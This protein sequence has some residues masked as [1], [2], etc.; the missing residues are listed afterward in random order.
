MTELN[1]VV[2]V[3]GGETLCEV[4]FPVAYSYGGFAQSR[5]TMPTPALNPIG[6]IEVPGEFA[7][8]FTTE[9]ADGTSRNAAVLFLRA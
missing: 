9:I 1:D 3:D 4:R 7:A 8:A 6:P 2:R 5:Y